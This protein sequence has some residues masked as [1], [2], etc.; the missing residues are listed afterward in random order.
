MI[1]KTLVQK[2]GSSCGWLL[3]DYAGL[4]GE[5]SVCPNPLELSRSGRRRRLTRGYLGYYVF[6]LSVRGV[7]WL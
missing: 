2:E 4:A 3:L 6:D 5:L 7:I 1:W